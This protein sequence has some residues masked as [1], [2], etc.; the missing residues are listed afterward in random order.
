[1]RSFTFALLVM[2]AIV[3]TVAQSG[4]KQITNVGPDLGIPVSRAVEADGLIYVAGTAATDAT[5]Q[6]IAGD[7]TAQTRQTLDNIAATLEAAGSNLANAASAIV[8]LRD[9]SDFGAMNT[10][11]RTYWPEDP[12]ARTTVR[13]PLVDPAA[14]IQISMVAIPNGGERVVVT[15]SGWTPPGLLSYGIKTGNTVFLAGLTGRNR[16]DGSI[17]PDITAQTRTVLETGAAILDAAGL[18]L[19][20]VVSSRVFVSDIALWGDMNVGYQPFFPTD[21]PARAA[22]EAGLVNPDYLVEI[23]LVAV[24][25]ASRT[26][27]STPAADGTPGKP[28]RIGS[29][30]IRVGNRLYVG[31]LLGRTDANVGDA[32]A[33]TVETLARIERTMRLAGFEWKDVV[34]GVVYLADISSQFADVD[35]VYRDVF[36]KDFPARATVGTTLVGGRSEVEIMLTA[37]K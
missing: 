32:K 15:P 22:V 25:D 36:P 27:F 7:I 24:R 8:Y 2:A 35:A 23:K 10:V 3:T 5:G 26:A 4:S 16:E 29:N 11:Y 9:L 14:L 34:D 1:M 17:A 31:G 37:V 19:A 6:V 12:P 30:A 13:A 33:Q 28:G 20:D 18:T 21:P